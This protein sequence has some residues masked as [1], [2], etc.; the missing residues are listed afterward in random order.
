MFSEALLTA[1][2]SLPRSGRPPDCFDLEMRK[3]S[4]E[5]EGE[6]GWREGVM[7]TD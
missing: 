1:N 4:R 5:E 2:L 6:P 7:E 3:Y